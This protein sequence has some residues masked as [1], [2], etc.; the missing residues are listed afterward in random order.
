MVLEKLWKEH[1]CRCFGKHRKLEVDFDGKL[2][3]LRSLGN[4]CFDIDT[5]N[6]QQLFSPL[7][8]YFDSKNYPL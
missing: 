2:A 1:R 4:P 3:Q 8:T 7:N 5:V 6:S